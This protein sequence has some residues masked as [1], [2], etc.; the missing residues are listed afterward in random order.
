MSPGPPERSI[1]S[2]AGGEQGLVGDF[3]VTTRPPPTGAA[4]VVAYDVAPGPQ[5]RLR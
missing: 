1:R 5:Q 2:A 3:M 4:V